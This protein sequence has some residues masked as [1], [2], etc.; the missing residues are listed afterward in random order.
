MAIAI[1]SFSGMIH[2]LIFHQLLR[3][4]QAIDTSAVLDSCFHGGDL[5]A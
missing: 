4:Y 1:S 3:E 2:R 5:K